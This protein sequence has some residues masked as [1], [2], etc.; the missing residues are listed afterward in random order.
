VLAKR[1]V[2][3]SHNPESN[4][5]LASGT[6]PVP[7]MRTVRIPV[8]LG[9]DGAASNNDLDMFEAMRQAAFLHKLQTGDPRVIPARTALEMATRE[10]ARALGLEQSI[11]SLEPGK[12]ADIIVVQMSRPR[13][14]PLFDPVA[15]VV[16]TTRGDDVET[17]IVNGKV[18][19]RNRQVLTLDES[20]VLGDA[21]AAADQVRKAVQ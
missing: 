1:G 5:K 18:L 16:Y 19:M 7:A 13:Q 8:G 17:T 20:R 4:M 9:T 21:R 2:G 10:G 6:A 11:G 14:Q 15:Q 12:R 3:V